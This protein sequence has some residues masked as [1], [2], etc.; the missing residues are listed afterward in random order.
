MRSLLSVNVLPE[1]GGNLIS[2]ETFEE[3]PVIRIC[4]G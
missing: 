4:Y 1:Y 2:G 3:I